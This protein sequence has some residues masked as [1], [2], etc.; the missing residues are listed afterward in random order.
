M[1]NNNNY[2]TKRQMNSRDLNKSGQN[3]DSEWQGE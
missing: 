3:Y 1:A 2:I